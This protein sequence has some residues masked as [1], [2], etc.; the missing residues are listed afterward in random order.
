MDVENHRHSGEFRIPR[1]KHEEVGDV[2]DMDDVVGL[3]E[4]TTG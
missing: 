2:M 3:S 1:G 4:V